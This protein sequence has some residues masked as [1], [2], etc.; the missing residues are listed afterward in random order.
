MQN[1]SVYSLLPVVMNDTGRDLDS[2]VALVLEDLHHST[3]VVDNAA[4]VLLLAAVGR[5]P[6]AYERVKAYVDVMRTTLTGN[7]H[8]RY[9]LVLMNCHDG[10]ANDSLT[11]Y[12][13]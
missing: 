11:C 1:S 12:T 3:T 4:R 6:P 5:D 2:T 9:A 8:W 10:T 13:V 7:I